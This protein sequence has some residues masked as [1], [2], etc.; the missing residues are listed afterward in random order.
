MSCCND[1]TESSDIVEFDHGKDQC[2]TNE[3]LS[4]FHDL[5]TVDPLADLCSFGRFTV[6]WARET[7]TA[8]RFDIEDTIL[9]TITTHIYP[10]VDSLETPTM[11]FN[12]LLTLLGLTLNRIVD[13]EV[14]GLRET[15]N[16]I[17]GKTE[18]HF[19]SNTKGFIFSKHLDTVKYAKLSMQIETRTV[20]E[21]AEIPPNIGSLLSILLLTREELD[22]LISGTNEEAIEGK[23]RELAEYLIKRLTL[24]NGF[25]PYETKMLSDQG[26]FV[27][28]LRKALPVKE[29][30]TEELYMFADVKYVTDIDLET[31]ASILNN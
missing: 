24:V 11:A 4:R 28:K 10:S 12:N 26:S 2:V 16:D 15:L 1:V 25:Q 23:T 20:T 6:R 21:T 19:A 5:S 14:A 31:V 30:A 3:I 13:G 8:I 17:A 22:A 9:G 7:P 29:L 27:I 18:Y